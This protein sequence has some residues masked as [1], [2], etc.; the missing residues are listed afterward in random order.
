M[1]QG[2]RTLFGPLADFLCR[3]GLLITLAVWIAEAVEMLLSAKSLQT[4][5]SGK[6]RL[7]TFKQARLLWTALRFRC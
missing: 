4:G 5:L 7:L 6:D 2:H 1:E 3:I